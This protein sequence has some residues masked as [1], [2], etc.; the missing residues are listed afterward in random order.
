[1]S[2]DI[3]ATMNSDTTFK[4]KPQEFYGS[5]DPVAP[6]RLSSP[7]VKARN[8]IPDPYNTYLTPQTHETLKR[9]GKGTMQDIYRARD[10]NSGRIVHSHSTDQ[11]P[12][13]RGGTLNSAV[14]GRPAPNEATVRSRVVD[15]R[16]DFV[17]RR[18]FVHVAA[19][20]PKACQNGI[21]LNPAAFHQPI[22]TG[23]RHLIIGDSL[24]SDL[25]ER[26]VVGQTSAISFGEASVEQ[27]IK[28]MEQQNDETV[29]ETI[30]ISRNP[31]DTESEV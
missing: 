3:L 25:M 26:F 8:T 14:P 1:M 5:S 29:I 21:N 24:I 22:P 18:I 23:S 17:T 12:A 27:V 16:A 20:H 7:A 15:I 19:D 6:I 11:S 10:R 9:V 4:T 30:E 2:P 31:I 13:T 28:M